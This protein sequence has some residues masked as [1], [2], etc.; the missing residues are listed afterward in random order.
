M[1]AEIGQTGAFYKGRNGF[2][3]VELLISLMILSIILVIV[4][5]A[6]R[7]GVRAWEKGE[8]DIDSNQRSRIVLSLIKQQLS[9]IV[10][11]KTTI[12]A[13]SFFLKGDAKSLEFVS[14]LSLD[15]GNEFGRVYVKYVVKEK[16]DKKESLAFYERNIVFMDKEF[17]PEN[18]DD[19]DFHELI[20]DA[21]DVSFEYLKPPGE[22]NAY[23][24]QETWDPENDSGMPPAVKIIL[25]KEE[26]TAPITVIVRIIPE[27]D[28]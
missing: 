17:N 14:M 1:V 20:P 5:G 13:Q 23:E 22:E 19:N 3:L 27:E 24:W 15:P 21:R 8:Q 16:E 10:L 12:D 26:K 18:L 2:T 7:V 11:K 25:K 4:L 9:S 28:T 6:F